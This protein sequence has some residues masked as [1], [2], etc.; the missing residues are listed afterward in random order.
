MFQ[1]NVMS[2][3][4]KRHQARLL[5]PSGLKRSLHPFGLTAGLRCRL[6]SA[7][8]HTEPRG[9][10][11]AIATLRKRTMQSRST[12]RER[13]KSI[14]MRSGNSVSLI[15]MKHA[16]EITRN[17]RCATIHRSCITTFSTFAVSLHLSNFVARERAQ[18]IC[19]STPTDSRP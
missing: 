7:A 10:K 5:R 16:A 6:R 13:G 18:Q 14:Q 9:D 15:Q 12:L 8:R 19:R 1:R 3:H 4:F 2:S 11:T 17:S